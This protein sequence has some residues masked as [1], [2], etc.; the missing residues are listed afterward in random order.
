M[1]NITDIRTA[2]EAITKYDFSVVFIGLII[3]ALG[4]MNVYSATRDSSFTH[5]MIFAAIGAV[6]MII[7][8]FI[9]YRKL[10]RIIYAAYVANVLLLILVLL[11]GRSAMGA[12]R[13]LSFGFIN[14]QP[15]EIMKVT[16]MLALAKYFSDDINIRG[17]TLK[18]L[19]V[20]AIIVMVPAGL[21]VIQP[22]LGSGLLIMFAAFSLFL[23]VKIRVQSII[24]LAVAAII[25]VPIVYNFALKDYQKK[26]VIT[27]LNPELDPKGAGYN[28]LQSKIAVG[29]GRLFGK[30]FGKGSQ[31]QLNF[32][33][34]HHT[35]F[36]FSVMGE[37][38]G[39][40]GSFIL[41]ILYAML[42]VS[43][44]RIASRAGDKMGVLV[45]VGCTAIIFWQTFIN[46]GM[47]IG[48]MP[49]VGITL[50]FM[51]YG[52]TSMVVNFIIIGLLQNIAIRRFMF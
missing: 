28:S 39:F 22:D 9:D 43:G 18:Q 4:L 37:E 44:A 27:F 1:R 36:I 23:F 35:D 52:G 51:S 16:M 8:T 25:T 10:G 21:V 50:P 29:S 30:G 49:V 46:I 40:L 7:F 15:A 34:E 42:F 45:A 32:L 48:I 33:P 2:Y 24:I 47:V 19:L 20:P 17:Y 26:R 6:M 31:T 11:I 3:T 41:L 38:H 14:I 5:Q 13:W 12:T